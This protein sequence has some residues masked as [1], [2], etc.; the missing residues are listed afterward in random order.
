[1]IRV[2][3]A[4][5][6]LQQ[7][8]MGHL[9]YLK[10]LLNAISTLQDK[11]IE[12]IILLGEKTEGKLVRMFEPYAKIVRSSIFDIKSLPWFTYKVHYK[13]TGSQRFIEQLARKHDITVFSHSGIYGNNL[14]FK[15]INWI[16]DFQHLN[17]PEMFS[18]QEIELRNRQ[19]SNIIEKSDMVVLSSFDAMD[20]YKKFAPAHIDKARVMQFVSQPTKKVYEL[21]NILDM[22][23]KY[24]FNGKFF[25]L[26]NRFWK[27][28][29]H[30]VVFEAVRILKERKS[31]VLVLC[32]GDMNDY[33]NKGHIEEIEDYISKHDIG[34]SVR[35]LGIIDYDDVLSL[36][37]HSISVLNPSLFEGW[38]STV[39]EAKSIGKSTILSN[40]KVHIEQNPP[41]SSY[42]DPYNAEELADILWLKW[43]E[44]QGGPEI[45]LE[46]EARL[47]L[48][49]RTRQFAE[50][51]QSFVLEI[52]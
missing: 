48:T 30:K 21:N 44:S 49:Q 46:R 32:S 14:S 20:D 17:L 7:G 41:G 19:C 31:D 8:L 1:M 29:N 33:R 34:N 16:G 5:I 36:M 37:R 52:L 35:L 42:F 13:M 28:K 15:T 40:L 43:N 3:F 4:N 25:F 9:N 12:P 50:K 2:A 22:E 18:K 6:E 10:N 47:N 11:K 39:E 38:S 26:P 27:H 24:K 23:R 45:G 51:F